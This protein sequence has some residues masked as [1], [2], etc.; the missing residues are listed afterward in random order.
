MA[1]ATHTNVSNYMSI[2]AFDTVSTPTSTEVTAMIVFADE[3]IDDFI[4]GATLSTERLKRASCMIVAN[5]IERGKKYLIAPD[6][7]TD[8]YRRSLITLE[9]AQVLQEGFDAASDVALIVSNQEDYQ[10]SS[11][12]DDFV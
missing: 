9:V 8:V 3:A 10:D 6:E 5:M 4:G 1:Y 2:P 12:P 7:V 11:D